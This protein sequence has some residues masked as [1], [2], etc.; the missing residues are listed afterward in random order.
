[1][2]FIEDI[3]R[4]RAVYLVSFRGVLEIIMYNNSTVCNEIKPC[5]VSYLAQ[6]GMDDFRLRPFR[7]AALNE[8]LRVLD[9]RLQ[10]LNAS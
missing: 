1:M 8:E 4:G 3:N 5:I 2:R 6:Q 10:Q 9:L 7:I